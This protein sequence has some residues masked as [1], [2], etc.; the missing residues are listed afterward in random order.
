MATS[1]ELRAPVKE[2]IWG[3]LL[4]LGACWL[5]HYSFGN[6]LDELALI[7]RAQVAPGSLVETSEHEEEDYRGHVYFSDVGVYTYRLPDGREFKTLVRV[8][9]GGLKE[10]QAVEYLP[11]NPA[12]SRIKGHG[13]Q[14]VGEWLW[15]KVG[16]G[17][18]LL[19]LFVSP[20]VVLLRD[21]VRDMRKPSNARNKTMTEEGLPEGET[22]RKLSDSIVTFFARR[23][24]AIPSLVAAAMLFAAMGKWPYDYYRILRWVVCAGAAF[25]A[26]QGWAFRKSWA[27]WLFGFMAV[28]F[29]PLV[30]VHFG[31]GTWQVIDLAAAAAFV[32]VTVAL[33]KPSSSVKNGKPGESES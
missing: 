25:V 33:A 18:L 31:R 16:L 15:R 7:R 19:A 1:N 9:T 5:W 13:C 27:S 20:G 4:V 6:L 12:V 10:Q 29:N 22:R 21:G 2:L 24:H 17:G 14:S 8:P 28:L 30:A 3:V 11:D 26:Y 23:P 32:V